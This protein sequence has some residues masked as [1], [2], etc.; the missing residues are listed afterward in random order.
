MFLVVPRDQFP[1]F[2]HLDQSKL[3]IVPHAS[4]PVRLEVP[5]ELLELLDELVYLILGHPRE[6]VGGAL[7][8]RGSVQGAEVQGLPV[9]LQI[10]SGLLVV[11][12]ERYTVAAKC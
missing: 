8:G 6:P 5:G 1:V 3:Q 9:A 12:G 11:L 2:L 4:R 7:E 10:V